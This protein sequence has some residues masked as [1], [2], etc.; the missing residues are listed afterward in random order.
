M[1]PLSD[2][3][4]AESQSNLSILLSASVAVKV[5]FLNLEVHSK[6]DILLPKFAS[7]PPEVTSSDPNRWFFWWQNS[8]FLQGFSRNL[9]VDDLFHLEKQFTSERLHSLFQASWT[10]SKQLFSPESPL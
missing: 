8:L 1:L 10:Q 5:L 3:L 7:Y 4:A 9:S 6:R 2:V